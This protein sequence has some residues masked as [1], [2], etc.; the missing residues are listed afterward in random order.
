MIR[1]LSYT[2]LLFFFQGLFAIYILFRA[3][4][5]LSDA[6]YANL[7][8]NVFIL[9]FPTIIEAGAILYSLNIAQK[10]NIRLLFSNLVSVR[11]IQLVI[12]FIAIFTQYFLSQNFPIYQAFLVFIF[13]AIFLYSIPHGFLISLRKGYDYWVGLRL[14]YVII[15][16]ILALIC[17]EY[18][19][20]NEL[21]LLALI[22]LVS[23]YIFT[24]LFQ[25][26]RLR[27]KCKSER[28][29]I[30]KYLLNLFPSAGIGVILNSFASL[31]TNSLDNINVAKG[32]MI[33]RQI[34]AFMIA[35]VN[36]NMT[37]LMRVLR[38]NVELYEIRDYLSK[39]IRLTFLFAPLVWYLIYSNFLS[40]DIAIIFFI[41]LFFSRISFIQNIYLVRRLNYKN[42]LNIF[43][44]LFVFTLGLPWINERLY[45][46]G[47]LLVS[48]LLTIIINMFLYKRNLTKF[49]N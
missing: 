3:P 10:D 27:F 12:L 9:Q 28:K 16:L 15:L 21:S 1:W 26:I 41:W 22:S 46:P 44:I 5:L 29:D 30:S 17:F 48:S 13:G 4:S 49:V 38:K 43:I 23:V 2:K 6:A 19:E 32:W 11:K 45:F 24:G 36:M 47:V 37:K 33:F 14:I 42:L 40:L 7:L 8:K 18:F 31:S 34:D 25:R 39:Q 35:I 20:F